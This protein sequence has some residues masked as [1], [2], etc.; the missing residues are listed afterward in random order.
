ME[1]T[2]REAHCIARLLQSAI[3]S[4]DHEIFAGCRFCK[5]Q[6]V[7]DAGKWD[8]KN[9][10]D[11]PVYDAVMRRLMIQTGV[12]VGPMVYGYLEPGGMPYKKFLKN[13]NEG[14]KEFFRNQ[15]KNI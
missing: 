10:V 7:K 5:Y 9:M 13:S 14:I 12:D 6:C 11:L 2:K 3:F 8:D 4:P 15:F 1:L